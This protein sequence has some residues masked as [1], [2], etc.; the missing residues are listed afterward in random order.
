MI[1][2]QNN[3]NALIPRVYVR[4]GR[5]SVLE[6]S[7]SKKFNKIRDLLNAVNF[8]NLMEEFAKKMTNDNRILYETS[9]KPH[10]YEK[11]T[12]AY[13]IE[14]ANKYIK[15]MHV[16]YQS[17][18]T[19]KKKVSY[20]QLSKLIALSKENKIHKNNFVISC[21]CIIILYV[22]FEKMGELKKLKNSKQVNNISTV[23]NKYYE[24]NS[25]DELANFIAE[26]VE[27]LK[28]KLPKTIDSKEFPSI[29]NSGTE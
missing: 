6:W 13:I 26:C 29:L 18:E 9:K 7:N 10:M 14:C 17:S 16:A 19:M 25:T 28:N 27:V 12:K 5:E 3:I 8:Y 20:R 1:N 23:V 2:A 4:M 15:G 24:D 22:M 21:Y 11:R